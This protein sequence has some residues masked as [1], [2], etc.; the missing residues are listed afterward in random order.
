[1]PHEFPSSSDIEE[2]LREEFREELYEKHRQFGLKML[3]YIYNADPE[4][5]EVNHDYS[6]PRGETVMTESEEEAIE[7]I[8]YILKTQGRT[9]VLYPLIGNLRAFYP[10][11]EENKLLFYVELSEA[12][13]LLEIREP[14]AALLRGCSFFEKILSERLGSTSSLAELIEEA[15]DAGEMT[16]EEERLAQ[17]VRECRNDAGHNFWLETEYSYVVHEHGVISLLALLESMLA[18]WFSTRWG[19]VPPRLTPERCLRI[20]E[21]EFSFE[22]N[23]SGGL[24]SWDTGSMNS[25]Y[26]RK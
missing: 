9:G 2:A 3:A 24:R 14:F 26:D 13:R 4:S 1:M 5:I 19:T 25:R 21:Q 16:E 10:D 6:I 11:E 7:R 17:F 20:I 15:A 8:K 22:W 18:S 12:N 23:P